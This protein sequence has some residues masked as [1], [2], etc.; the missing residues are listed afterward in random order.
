MTGRQHHRGA[1]VMFDWS[2]NVTDRDRFDRY[3]S[4]KL[5]PS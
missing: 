1:V 5:G 4:M 3:A 2:T